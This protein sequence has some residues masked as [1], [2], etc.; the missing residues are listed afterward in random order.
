MPDIMHQA[1]IHAPAKEIFPLL[2]TKEGIQKWLSPQDG[3]KIKGEENLGG[4]LDFYFHDSHHTMKIIK[5]ENDK[6]VRWECVEGPE[7]WLGT[8]VDFFI[9]DNVK[10]CT[11][12]FAHNGW[13]DQTKFFQQCDVVWG[14][15][16]A[17]IKKIAEG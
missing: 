7:E 3:W 2:S 5:L 13:A 10:K 17:A 15:N 1:A 6:Q 16:V 12:Q 14:R 9:E 8:T 11:L 4:K